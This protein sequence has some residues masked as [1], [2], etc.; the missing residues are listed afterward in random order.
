MSVQALAVAFL[1][2]TR[3]LGGAEIQSVR[4]AAALARAGVEPRVW[5]LAGSPV[6]AFAARAGL[7]V[8]RLG[9]GPVAPSLVRCVDVLHVHEPRDLPWAL[10][11]ARTAGVPVVATRHLAASPRPR[12]DPYHAWLV[13]RVRYVAASRF[14]QRSLIA[15]YGLGAEDIAVVPYGYA[16]ERLVPRRARGPVLTIGMLSRLSD[17]KHL[18]DAVAVLATL[19]GR[20]VAT[21]LFVAGEETD[22][23]ARLALLRA[24]REHGVSDRL[25]LLGHRHD[26]PALLA[27]ADLL[28]HTAHAESFGLAV[29]EAMAHR[30]PVVAAAG[31]GIPELVEHGRTGWLAP[32]GDVT[33]LA[34]GVTAIAH[35][36]ALAESLASAARTHAATA[37]GPALEAERLTRL[38]G[39]VASAGTLARTAGRAARIETSRE[40]GSS[41]MRVTSSSSSGGSKRLCG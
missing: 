25:S 22:R 9:R 15:A 13:R 24:A 21:E 12:R 17:G 41:V 2:R 3:S 26:V 34:D 35:S 23:G 1:L 31:G 18:A 11:A 29:L 40:S 32:P 19:A 10:L 33:A 8:E 14:V 37:F 38:Y 7:V 27:R 28:L 6:A 39:E 36:A 20:G 5:T 4:A 16:P 30:C